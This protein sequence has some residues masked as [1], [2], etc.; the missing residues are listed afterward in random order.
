MQSR[1]LISPVVL[2]FIILQY[3]LSVLPSQSLST[4][5]DG[6][7]THPPRFG[8]TY[9]SQCREMLLKAITHNVMILLLRVFYRALLT[10]FQAAPIPSKSL[11]QNL[12]GGR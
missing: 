4:V 9:H 7:R 3:S 11:S 10:P 12:L 1:G 6:I 2:S 8:L 5:I